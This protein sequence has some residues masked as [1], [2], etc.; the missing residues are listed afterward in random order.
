L[1]YDLRSVLPN[2]LLQETCTNKLIKNYA[3]NFPRL[4]VKAGERSPYNAIAGEIFS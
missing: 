1:E 3:I 2:H 4:F